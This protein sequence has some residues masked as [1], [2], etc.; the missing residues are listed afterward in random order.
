MKRIFIAIILVLVFSL[1]AMAIELTY[2]PDVQYLA[3]EPGDT[4]TVPLTVGIIT[5]SRRTYYLWFIDDIA[6][7]IPSEWIS[8]SKGTSFLSK[9]WSTASTNISIAV[10]EDAT[11]GIYES[12]LYSH[13]MGVHSTDVTGTGMYLNLTVSSAC[14]ATPKFVIDGVSPE[15][16]WPPNGSIEEVIVAGHLEMPEGC[17]LYEIGYS[18]DDEYGTFSSMGEV[19]INDAGAFEAVIPVEASR[20]GQDKDGRHYTVNLYA[21]NEAGIGQSDVIEIIVP[22]DKRK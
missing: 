7:S 20:N 6:G 16:L 2:S 12:Y 17:N 3:A 21:E 18:V 19:A 5:D 10:P 4:V 1:P 14:G 15:V 22:H 11:P 8:S 9:W 13:I